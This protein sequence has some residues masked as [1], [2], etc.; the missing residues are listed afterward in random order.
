MVFGF[1]GAGFS[2]KSRVYTSTNWMFYSLFS[3]LESG[4]GIYAL[5]VS[6]VFPSLAIVV[7]AVEILSF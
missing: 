6:S 2:P 4:V 1:K 5:A 7:S 3:S